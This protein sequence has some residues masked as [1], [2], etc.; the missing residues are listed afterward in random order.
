MLDFAGSDANLNSNGAIASMKLN[1]NHKICSL[2]FVWF[3]I[4]N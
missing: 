1:Q 3:K 4:K 2:N